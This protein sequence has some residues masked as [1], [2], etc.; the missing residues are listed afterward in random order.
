MEKH[1]VM[2]WIPVTERLPEE[3]DSIFAKYYGSKRWNRSMFRKRSNKVIVATKF[4]DG[5]INVEVGSTRDGEWK[6]EAHIIPREVIAWMP[7]PVPPTDLD[8]E[9][10]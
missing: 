2:N 4:P 8:K 5:T 3:H 1:R 9:R 10:G 7:M 6:F